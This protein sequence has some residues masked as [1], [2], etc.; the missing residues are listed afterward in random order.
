MAY[1]KQNIKDFFPTSN[2]LPSC[3][4]CAFVHKHYQEPGKYAIQACGRKPR[5][6]YFTIYMGINGP[7]Q[8]DFTYEKH[9]NCKDKGITYLFPSYKYWHFLIITSISIIYGFSGKINCLENCTFTDSPAG[10]P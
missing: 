10:Q 3:C 8:T 9:P 6:H 2:R 5:K 7:F 1:I 4:L